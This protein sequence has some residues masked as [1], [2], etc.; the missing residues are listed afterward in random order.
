M[1]HLLLRLFHLFPP[2]PQSFPSSDSLETVVSN[3]INIR[4]TAVELFFH[5]EQDSKLLREKFFSKFKSDEFTY[6]IF[7]QNKSS[8]SQN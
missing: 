8:T 6:D 2:Q 5:G 7:S 1:R 4:T 3:F